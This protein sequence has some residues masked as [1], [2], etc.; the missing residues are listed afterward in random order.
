MEA[1]NSLK[2]ILCNKIPAVILLLFVGSALASGQDKISFLTDPRYETEWWFPLIKKHNIDPNQFSFGGNL[3]PGAN[4]PDEYTALELGGTA[5]INNKIITIN[6]AAF[7]IKEK[8]DTYNLITAKS[9]SHD[10]VDGK[11]RF[12]CGKIEE[13]KF[14]SSELSPVR[15]SSFIKLQMDPATKEIVITG[16]SNIQK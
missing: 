14:K 10:L 12:E 1:R 6:D 3:K 4:E 11:I 15:S 9:A 7:F 2:H 13:Y 16:I 5:F 8:D